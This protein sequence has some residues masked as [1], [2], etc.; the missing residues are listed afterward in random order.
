M[1]QDAVP[2][3]AENVENIRNDVEN[4]RDNFSDVIHEL[5]R[6][7][8]EIDWRQELADH[9]QW[10]GLAG[11]AAATAIG[12]AIVLAIRGRRNRRKPLARLHELH[13]AVVRGLTQTEIIARPRRSA[14]R[15]MLS[16]MGSALVAGLLKSAAQR[17]LAPPQLESR[18]V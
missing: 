9:P 2:E 18:D 13:N 5:D 7:R 14:A 6:R 4:I 1:I 16:V 10:V 8:K 3:V 11:V 17:L 15:R 12:G